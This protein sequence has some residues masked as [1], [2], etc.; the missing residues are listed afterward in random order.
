MCV[1]SISTILLY[2]LHEHVCIVGLNVIF[3]LC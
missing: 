1:L 2:V 3:F